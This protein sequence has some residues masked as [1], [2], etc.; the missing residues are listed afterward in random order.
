MKA[1]AIVRIRIAGAAIKGLKTET[2]QSGL[3]DGFD[4]AIWG[5]NKNI[6]GGYPYLIANP[7]K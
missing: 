4:P 1:M 2:F 7:P 5:Q 6:N 3:P